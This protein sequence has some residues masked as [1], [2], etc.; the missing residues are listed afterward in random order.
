MPKTKTT[1]KTKIKAKTKPH[2][3]KVKSRNR[4]TYK[5]THKA[6]INNGIDEEIASSEYKSLSDNSSVDFEEYRDAYLRGAERQA[7]AIFKK[8]Y[9]VDERNVFHY[10]QYN[11]VFPKKKKS[12]SN[13]APQSDEVK[14]FLDE[15]DFDLPEDY[16]GSKKIVMIFGHSSFGDYDTFKSTFKKN[17]KEDTIS[18]TKVL[19]KYKNIQL[20][21]TQSI[22]RYGLVSFKFDFYKLLQ[23]YEILYNALLELKTQKHANNLNKLVE[24]YFKTFDRN[25]YFRNL[26]SYHREFGKTDIKITQFRVYPK[27]TSPKHPNNIKI[28]FY[29]FNRKPENAEFRKITDSDVYDYNTKYNSYL[30][31]YSKDFTKKMLHF[32]RLMNHE[33]MGILNITKMNKFGYHEISSIILENLDEIKECFM[34]Q[35]SSAI[36]DVEIIKCALLIPEYETYEKLKTLLKR[37]K[38]DLEVFFDEINY[39]LH[40]FD[41]ILGNINNVPLSNQFGEDYKKNRPPILDLKSKGIPI[42]T[43]IEYI[44]DLNKKPGLNEDIL[45]IE[46][47]CKIIHGAPAKKKAAYDMVELEYESNNSDFDPKEALLAKRAQ[48]TQEFELE[49]RSNS[50]NNSEKS[51][52]YYIEQLRKAE[53]VSD[54]TLDTFKLNDYRKFLDK[55]NDEMNVYE[56]RHTINN[57]LQR[58]AKRHRFTRGE[59]RNLGSATLIVEQIISILE[60][61]KSRHK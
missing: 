30:N 27:D 41:F 29:P 4:K 11:R 18:R 39:N 1:L 48:S 23:K 20:L 34:E 55:L 56:Q 37:L 33:I 61:N 3:S 50:A 2:T 19:N 24:H 38:I 59:I 28:N 46:N 7:K 16:S 53:V 10:S 15:M 26:N 49:S 13:S 17:P 40:I 42:D 14:S 25:Q 58:P 43:L 22:G 21:S 44:H 51:L 5:R 54:A 31:T 45:I 32:K 52:D 57:K 8:R 9:G 60:A 47:S 12:S 36:T 6:E 35:N